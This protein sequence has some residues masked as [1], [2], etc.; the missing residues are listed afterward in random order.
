LQHFEK[1]TGFSVAATKT[2]GIL[3]FAKQQIWRTDAAEAG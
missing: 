1:I 2:G 3:R